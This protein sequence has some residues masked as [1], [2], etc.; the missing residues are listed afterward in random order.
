ME[1][2]TTLV[3]QQNVTTT[4]P[5]KA[6]IICLLLAWVF[7]LL[8]IPGIS[9]GG[10]VVF[11]IAAIILAIICMSRNAVKPGVG[12]LAGSIIGT[13]I[14]YFVGMAVLGAGIASSLKGYDNHSTHQT[15]NNPTPIVQSVAVQPAK[16]T[17][18]ETIL[19]SASATA[20]DID[21]N[22][23]GTYESHGHSPTP[24]SMVISNFSNG[25]FDGSASEQIS[26][27]GNVV[28][29]QSKLTGA[30]NAKDVAFTKAFSFR[31]KQYSVKYSGTY[32]PVTKRIQGKW[33]GLTVNSRGSFLVWR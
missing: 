27:A 5:V 23:Q 26:S 20:T 3:I 1:S 9:F 18:V 33:K 16:S 28:T 21:G 11:N 2:Q 22:W 30:L 10:M 15:Q 14:M 8:P 4:A 19:P 31:G 25:A 13:T 32:D 12:V 7:A 17:S 29:I 24:F 6:A